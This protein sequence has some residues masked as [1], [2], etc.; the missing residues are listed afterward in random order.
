MK[1]SPCCRAQAC[2]GELDSRNA[3][4]EVLLPTCWN[5][6]F[7]IEYPTLETATLKC[8]NIGYNQMTALVANQMRL[9][10]TQHLEVVVFDAIRTTNFVHPRAL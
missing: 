6:C 8:G 2:P 7:T 3:N 10:L 1:I 9:A 5:V 4:I